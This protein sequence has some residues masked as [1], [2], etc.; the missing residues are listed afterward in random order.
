VSAGDLSKALSTPAISEDGFMVENERRSAD[1]SA[2]QAGPTH[3]G[4]DPFDDQV[5]FEFRDR[6]DDDH[7]GAAQRAARVDLFAEADELRAEM[8]EFI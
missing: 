3:A 2:F 4:P 6:A 8:A 7:D 1:G 5:A